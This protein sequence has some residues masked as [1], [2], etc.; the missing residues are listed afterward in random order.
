MTAGW[1]DRGTD[2]EGTTICS[3][4]SKTTEQWEVKKARD[5]L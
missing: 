4:L 1:G 2:S 3:E 5:T